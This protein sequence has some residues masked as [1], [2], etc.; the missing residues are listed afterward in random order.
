M[1]NYLTASSYHAYPNLHLF[2]NYSDIANMVDTQ[3]YF[4]WHGDH[5]FPME[6]NS[7][8]IELLHLN[9]ALYSLA[10]NVI[11][12]LKNRRNIDLK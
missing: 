1:K 4:Q 8:E 11:K 10:R 12:E 3:C 6:E 7:K 2:F 9:E 5:F